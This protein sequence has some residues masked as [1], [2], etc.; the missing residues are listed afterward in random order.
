MECSEGGSPPAGWR[1]S[2]ICWEAGAYLLAGFMSRLGAVGA[3]VMLGMFV[4]ALTDALIPGHTAHPCGYFGPQANP[5][6]QVLAGGD[7]VR[8]WDVIRDMILAGLSGL[9]LYRGTSLWF[10]AQIVRNRQ[11][12]K[13]GAGQDEA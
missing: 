5:L 4:F 13:E 3:I 1:C 10:V 12:I 9:V 6:L 7:R 8:W 11:S 2:Q